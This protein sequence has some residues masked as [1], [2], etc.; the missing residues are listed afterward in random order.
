MKAGD[1]VIFY[2]LKVLSE[3]G[4]LTNASVI[5]LLTGDEESSGAP[6]AIRL[7][8]MLAAAKR[9]DL[10]LSFD[11]GGKNAASSAIRGQ[12]SW[13][14]EVTAKTGHS[15]LIFTQDIGSGA[16]FEAA[17][18]LDEFYQT[19]HN[20][21][22][23]SFNPGLVAGGSKIDDKKTGVTVRGKESVIP[24]KTIMFGD[25]RFISKQQEDAARAKMT[26]IVG[27]SLP[28]ASAKIFFDD[29]LPAMSPNEGNNALLK[30]LDAV[31]RT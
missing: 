25:L 7:E 21:K 15:S 2:A 16:I 5:V 24:A 26:E 18:I 29:G 17:R 8:G 19:L 28:G 22:Y 11:G 13:Y 4:A 14:I 9:S 6:K 20:E 10:A 12:S 1:V 3:T 30:Q 27:R 23:L 31:S